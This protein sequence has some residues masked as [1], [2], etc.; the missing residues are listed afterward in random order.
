V[1]I[2]APPGNEPEG[3]HDQRVL[4]TAGPFSVA[5]QPLQSRL[6]AAGTQRQPLKIN[7]K[8]V[9]VK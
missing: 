6:A 3:L 1:P 4:T 9:A 7:D 8:Y 5:C 2:V